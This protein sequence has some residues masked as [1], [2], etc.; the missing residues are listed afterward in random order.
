MC[1]ALQ[2]LV[3]CVNGCFQRGSLNSQPIMLD[4]W[5]SWCDLEQIQLYIINILAWESRICNSY[6]LLQDFRM[7]L[8]CGLAITP[9][10]SKFGNNISTSYAEP[11]TKGCLVSF[12]SLRLIY[13][14]VYV[15]GSIK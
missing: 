9:D 5:V 11:G 2:E 10:C 4:I 6:R 14:E 7:F 12:H 13:I 8:E 3:A 15:P 1:L